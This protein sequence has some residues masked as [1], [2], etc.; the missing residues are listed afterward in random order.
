MAE[1]NE[2]LD[3]D[4]EFV[5]IITLNNETIFSA[6]EL[7]RSEE[8]SFLYCLDPLLVMHDSSGGIYCKLL[9][10][11]TDAEYIMLFKS[12]ILSISTLSEEFI[13]LY[14]DKVNVFLSQIRDEKERMQNKQKLKDAGTFLIS[15]NKWVN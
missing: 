15:G 1:E 14:N 4:I 3:L 2:E 12:N 5:S 7:N 8:S 6:V 9:N 10:P 11:Y 13:D